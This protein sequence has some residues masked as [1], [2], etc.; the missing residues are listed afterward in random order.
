MCVCVCAGAGN[1]SLRLNIG[2]PQP[3]YLEGVRL[4]ESVGR[5]FAVCEAQNHGLSIHSI[6]DTAVRSVM[7]VWGSPLA[8]LSALSL[9]RRQGFPFGWGLHIFILQI[10]WQL[11]RGADSLHAPSDHC[12]QALPAPLLAPGRVV[13]CAHSHTC[14]QYL[15]PSVRDIFAG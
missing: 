13:S 9:T 11:L 10:A 1:L 4:A 7:V 2:R 12:F 15:P 8:V 3:R 5:D 6:L 14:A